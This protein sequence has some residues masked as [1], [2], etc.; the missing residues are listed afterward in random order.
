M[1]WLCLWDEVEVRSGVVDPDHASLML[2]GGWFALSPLYVC[3][4]VRGLF[5]CLKSCRSASEVCRVTTLHYAP[6]RIRLTSGRIQCRARLCPARLRRAG[7]GRGAF[8]RVHPRATRHTHLHSERR[9]DA[10]RRT[11]SHPVCA[12]RLRCVVPRPF[13]R[14][15]RVPR[16]SA[17]VP[18]LIRGTVICNAASKSCKLPSIMAKQH[19]DSI[20]V[21]S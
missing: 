1:L 9:Q 3:D 2:H 7:I 17:P 20:A 6:A 8:H 18:R 5:S 4:H 11:Q 16:C 10:R 14:P 15:T 13:A 12:R 21:P 19:D